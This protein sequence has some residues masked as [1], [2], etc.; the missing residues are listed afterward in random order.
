MAY[1]V[2][3]PF[4]D[5]GNYSPTLLAAISAGASSARTTDPTQIRVTFATEA[6][7]TAFIGTVGASMQ[8]INHPAVPDMSVDKSSFPATAAAGTV[9]A[10]LTNPF[11]GSTTYTAVTSDAPLTVSGSTITK[12]ATD[13]TSGL[14]YS[15]TVR[16]TSADGKREVAETFLFR[17]LASI[18]NA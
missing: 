11:T 12:T 6:A 3:L 5:S 9:V 13:G 2:D 10:T 17:A 1:T 15:I 7:A 16:A 18:A 4:L 14:V 8:V